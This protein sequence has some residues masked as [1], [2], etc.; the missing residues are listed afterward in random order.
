MAAW[1]GAFAK[2]E[3]FAKMTSLSPIAASLGVAI[4]G[5]AGALMRYQ[6]GR[7]I[8][9]WLGIPPMG[10]F[11]WPTL[12]ANTIGGLAMGLLVGC[13]ARGLGGHF[14]EHLRLVLGVG[15]LGG[16]TTFSSFSLETW[17]LMEDGRMGIALVYVLLSVVASIVALVC[18]LTLTRVF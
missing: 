5:G 18:G 15:L 11:P 7:G 3:S 12:A 4:G 2:I 17:L 1:R 16:F 8:T 9:A 6:L 14:E 13:L 10:G